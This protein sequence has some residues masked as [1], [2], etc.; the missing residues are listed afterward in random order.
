MFDYIKDTLSITFDPDLN[1]HFLVWFGDSYQ[2][3]S[4]TWT[5]SP[6]QIYI[7]DTDVTT[8]LDEGVIKDW[9]YWRLKDK[10][11]TNV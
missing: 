1:W 6:S 2:S 7:S 5:L 3:R 8:V 11:N 9:F 4:A 10:K